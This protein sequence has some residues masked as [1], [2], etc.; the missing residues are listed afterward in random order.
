MPRI[1]STLLF[2]LLFA[3]SI[4][5][6]QTGKGPSSEKEEKSYEIE[7]VVFENKLPELAGDEQWA[8]LS[9][10]VIAGLKDA[11]E[12][13]DAPAASSS[14]PAPSLAPAVAALG[15]DPSY[16]ILAHKLWVQTAE[17][18]K[19]AKPVRIR[20]KQ[21]GELDGVMKLYVSRFL[22]LEVDLLFRGENT[23]NLNATANPSVT[24]VAPAG[25]Q[26][27][28]I[29]ETRRVKSKEIHYFDHPKFGLV[30]RITPQSN[31]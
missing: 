25:E 11:I 12:P 20:S 17:A 31:K 28:E 29:S 24:V 30:V 14:S 27:Y 6:Q 10:P 9:P 7:V 8:P 26:L 2:Y 16:R 1:W 5:A 23:A 3:T 13:N 15:R 19:D 22:H 18:E 4:A 21:A